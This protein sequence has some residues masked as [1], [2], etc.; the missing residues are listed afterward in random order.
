MARAN[1]LDRDL[2][3]SSFAIGAEGLRRYAAR[4]NSEPW[5]CQ[6]CR[7]YF[8]RPAENDVPERL[9][10]LTGSAADEVWTLI[11]G[12]RLDY[13]NWPDD[14]LKQQ[15]RRARWYLDRGTFQGSEV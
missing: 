5:V 8:V 2:G 14:R 3:A 13:V 10:C 9:D 11:D 12:G 7:W 1:P 6:A 15:E 4:L